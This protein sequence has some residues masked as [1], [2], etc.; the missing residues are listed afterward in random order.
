M[1]VIVVDGTNFQ[2]IVV[3][4]DALIIV[5]NRTAEGDIKVCKREPVA[6]RRS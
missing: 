2:G 1:P 4:P 5:A 3:R 6:A